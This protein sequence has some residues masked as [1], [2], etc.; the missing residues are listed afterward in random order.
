MF[1]FNGFV[2][3]NEFRL[4][5]SK[6]LKVLDPVYLTLTVLNVQRLRDS[7]QVEITSLLLVN[8]LFKID[9]STTIRLK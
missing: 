6:F 1:Y 8:I 9:G 3:F 5:F 7:F 4:I 2:A